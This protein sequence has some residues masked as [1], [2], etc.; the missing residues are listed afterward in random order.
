MSLSGPFHPPA[1]GNKPKQLVIFLHG[2]GADGRDLISLA[3]LFAES[4]ID[5]HFLSPNAPSACDMAPYGYQW[6]SLLSWNPSAMCQGANG[7]T[8]VLNE[9]IDAQLKILD[10]KDKDLALV[11]FSQ[12][13]MMAMHT[14]P[15]RPQPIAGIVGFSGALLGPELLEREI[16]SKPPVCLIHGVMDTVVPFTM[17][18]QAEATLKRC[19][20]RVESHTRPH[21]MHGIDPEGIEIAAKFL[22][23]ALGT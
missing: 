9:Y 7:V 16:K 6:F 13:T 14:A 17:M 22:K 5:A 18:A 8:P 10:L 4:L 19:G 23:E 11:G 12:G 2:L 1:S 20:V 15:R 21:L 3:P